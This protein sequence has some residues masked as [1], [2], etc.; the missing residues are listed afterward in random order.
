MMDD[1]I[2]IEMDAT[3]GAAPPRV[4]AKYLDGAERHFEE[5]PTA[6]QLEPTENLV[7]ITETKIV[8]RDTPIG[9][10]LFKETLVIHPA[11]PNRSPRTP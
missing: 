3:T 11:S 1:E 2:R 7:S 6:A 9:V 8:S 4:V 10:G 5:W